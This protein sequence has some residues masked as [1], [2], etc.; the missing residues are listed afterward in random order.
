MII[1]NLVLYAS[2]N[3]KIQVSMIDDLCP[4]KKRVQNEN[5]RRALP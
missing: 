4:N 1:K 3:P 5:C 2:V